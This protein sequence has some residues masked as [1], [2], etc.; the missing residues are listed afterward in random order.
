[1]VWRG[2]KEEGWGDGNPTAHDLQFLCGHHKAGVS[3]PHPSVGK[4]IG[5]SR[6]S[7]G[8][9]EGT[10]EAFFNETDGYD[11]SFFQVP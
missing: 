11:W 8:L 10:K 1:M 6:S 5:D 7:F 3:F 2:S 9:F 4:T